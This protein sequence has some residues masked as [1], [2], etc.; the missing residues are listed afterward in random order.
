MDE[1]SIRVI[2]LII[3][4]FVGAAVVLI[5]STGASYMPLIP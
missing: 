1:G 3:L 5:F 4:L 2:I